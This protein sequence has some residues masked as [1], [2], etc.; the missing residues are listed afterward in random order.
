MY[1]CAQTSE[2][3]SMWDYMH[4][5]FNWLKLQRDSPKSNIKLL[6]TVL[7]LPITVMP[8]GNALPVANTSIIN[9]RLLCPSSTAFQ[10][11]KLVSIKDTK[12]DC[13][14]RTKPWFFKLM[15]TKKQQID[16]N[17]C[18]EIKYITKKTNYNREIIRSTKL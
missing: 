17:A 1:P 6:N 14:V 9:S 18:I 15:S 3:I 11:P 2:N 4:W 5:C 10:C 8:F 7:A 16:L 13:S 12:T